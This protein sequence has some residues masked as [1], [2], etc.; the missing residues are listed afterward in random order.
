M[1]RSFAQVVQAV[2]GF[3]VQ[4]PSQNLARLLIRKALSQGIEQL[5]QKVF[6]ITHRS[7][8]RQK[9]DGGKTCR[10]FPRR[11]AFVVQRSGCDLSAKMR[12]VV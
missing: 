3:S 4:P 6:G 8:L 7:R 10:C 12:I 2:L 5:F 9:S 11:T 1:I